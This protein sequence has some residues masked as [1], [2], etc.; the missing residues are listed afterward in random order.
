MKYCLF[1]L[2]ALLVA[3]PTVAA[4]LSPADF[5]YGYN[6]ET[7]AEGAIF[8]VGV[9]DEIYHMAMR[10]DLGDLRVFNAAGEVVPHLLRPP[11]AADDEGVSRQD[12]PFFPLQEGREQ[13][14]ETDLALRVERNSQG[15]IVHIDARSDDQTDGEK[16]VLSYL[17]DL[18]GLKISARGF[19]LTWPAGSLST[20]TVSLQQ[21]D[22]L[23]HWFPLVEKAVLA[24]L[25]H[26]GQRIIQRTVHLPGKTLKY[27]KMQVV[28]DESL[29]AL[30]RVTVFSGRDP[31]MLQRH[32]LGLE[33]G[34]V[35]H[36]EEGISVAYL[37]PSRLPVNG[38]R[39][40]FREANS[41][42]RTV[43]QSRPDDKSPWVLR[44]SG[45][46]YTLQIQGVRIE[47]DLCALAETADRHWRLEVVEDGIG[48]EKPE[49]VPILE[50]GWIPAELLFLGRGPA[51]YTLA[52][53]SGRLVGEGGGAGAEMIRQ[54]LSL[55]DKTVLIRPAALGKR[56]ELGGK[57]ALQVPPPPLPWRQWLLWGL[58]FAGL[59]LMG[60]M[61][62]KLIREMQVHD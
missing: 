22:D 12:V 16:A 57:I 11:P 17:F 24:D 51:P 20:T 34:T 37:S 27:V 7:D 19:E 21:S 14:G 49:R 52:Y 43:V 46:F 42:L 15:T 62:K 59:V 6:L 4:D 58:L 35:G 36:N 61:V 30:D 31:V 1:F 3:G 18:S 32:W 56:L 9:P 5:A 8:S 53:G 38:V 25:Q 40:R 28:G 50:L 2:I 55:K 10:A 13:S 41:M 44:C 60:W 47:N 29:P 54:A 45:V 48:L 26:Q 39:L 33:K 23:V